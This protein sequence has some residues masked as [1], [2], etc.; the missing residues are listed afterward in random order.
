MNEF[1]NYQFDLFHAKL[2]WKSFESGY[3]RELWNDTIQNQI[4]ALSNLAPGNFELEA[5][6]IACQSY[7]GEKIKFEDILKQIAICLKELQNSGN[8]NSFT[9]CLFNRINLIVIQQ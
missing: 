3:I 1:E 8:K 6:I 2:K 7:F 4:K 9:M 5:H